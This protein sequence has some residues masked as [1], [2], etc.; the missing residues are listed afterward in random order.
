MAKPPWAL[1]E[2]TTEPAAVDAQTEGTRRE[3][4]IEER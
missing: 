1:S 2:R 3:L 4:R